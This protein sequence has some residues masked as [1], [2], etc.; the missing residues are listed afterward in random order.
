LLDEIIV[1]REGFTFYVG[2]EYKDLLHFAI[3]EE[4]SSLKQKLAD[5]IE[6]VVVLNNHEHIVSEREMLKFWIIPLL[7]ISIFLAK[8]WK[9]RIM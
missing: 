1:E 4:L 8:F 2:V 5:F 9:A 3:D 6:S 7:K